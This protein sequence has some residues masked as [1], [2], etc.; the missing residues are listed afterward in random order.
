MHNVMLSD[1]DIEILRFIHHHRIGGL[2]QLLYLIS[3]TT[4]FISIGIVLTILI[5]SL[6]TKS[7]PLR[8]IFYK[9]LAVLII[10]ATISFTLKNLIIRDRPFK[11]YPDIEKLSEAG[12]S[13]FPSGHTL[14]A[15]AIAVALSIL[16]HKR[17]F[18]I[19][20]FIWALL[21]AYSR[22]ALG[23]HYPSDVFSGM[24]IGSLIG[25][26]VPLLIRINKPVP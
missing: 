25:W 14:E 17:K 22:M 12:S 1:I 7:K 15:F 3:F 2:D 26:L 19:P 16:I 9:M 21:V 24:I 13:S 6:K 20:V 8:L 4:S 18:I 11:T 5:T 10:A 23:V